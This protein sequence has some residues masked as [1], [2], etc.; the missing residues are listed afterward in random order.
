MEDDEDQ[1]AQ[2]NKA[3]N[4]IRET[5]NRHSNRLQKIE[6]KLLNDWNNINKLEADVENLKLEV[7]RN[8]DMA[9]K[10][11][12]K[13]D[14]MKDGMKLRDIQVTKTMRKQTKWLIITGAVAVIALVYGTI[15][16]GTTASA[17][18]TLVTTLAKLG[19]VA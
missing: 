12:D 7:S 15:Q 18:S 10:T 6:A 17:I 2:L 19:L 4:E 3:I 5:Q 9:Q 13:V 16:N 1:F 14:E 8:S 11:M